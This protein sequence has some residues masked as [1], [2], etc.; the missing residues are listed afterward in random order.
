MKEE[1]ERIVTEQIDFVVLWV[2]GTDV[3]WQQERARFCPEHS[4]NGSSAN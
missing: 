4:N 2:D 3:E 1:G